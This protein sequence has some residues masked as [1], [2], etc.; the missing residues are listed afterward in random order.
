MLKGIGVLP[1]MLTGDNRQTAER[2]A[3][4][5][6]I[7][8]VIA[9]VLPEDKAQKVKALQQQSRKVAMVGDGVNDA[10]TLAQGDVGIAIG[11][12]TD[13]AIETADVVLMRSDP[14]D[15][16]TA[17]EIGP[18][19][20]T[21]NAPEPGL[22]DRLQLARSAGRRRRVRAL[23]ADAAAGDRGD[24]DVRL[25]RARCRERARAQAAASV[26]SNE[27]LSFRHSRCANQSR[28]EDST[29]VRA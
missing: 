5:L 23:W 19:D 17:V 24:L 9:E 3:H 15:V 6:G 28:R 10:P 26:G 8:E 2:I 14:L 7:E 29:R 1:V 22:G 25:E 4:E 18:R 27:R 13:V 20:R 11:A 21:Q 12:G 16:A